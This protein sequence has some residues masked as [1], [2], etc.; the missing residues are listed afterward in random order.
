M[1]SFLGVWGGVCVG[2]CVGF[3]LLL[4]TQQSMA[5]F[6][7]LSGDVLVDGDQK[8]QKVIEGEAHTDAFPWHFHECGMGCDKI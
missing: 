3:F 8:S 4:N 7:T 2:V 6:W 5:Y 1:G